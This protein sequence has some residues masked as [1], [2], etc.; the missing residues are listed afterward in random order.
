MDKANIIDEIEKL[1]NRLKNEVFNAYEKKGVA[2]GDKRFDAFKRVFIKT[3]SDII[4]SETNNVNKSLTQYGY[5]ISQFN[6]DGYN[7]WKNKGEKVNAYLE[8]LILDIKND[9]IDL[10]IKKTVP[11]TKTYPTMREKTIKTQ[12]NN[13]VFIVHGHDGEVKSRTA[14]FIEKLGFEAVILHEQASRGKTIIE[15][16]E[17]YTDVGFAIVLYTPDDTGNDI[18]SAGNGQYNLRARQNV[19]FEHGYLIAKI[20]RENVVPLVTDNIEL[21]NDISGVVYVSDSTWEVEIAKEMKQS[22][23]DVDFNKL[24]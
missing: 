7:F 23:Y 19:V 8:S 10:T 3:I 15:K 13:K 5:S 20:G 22:G 9:E 17:T 6:S 4:P 24:Y 2:Y 12:K 11:E 21:P 16:I 14:R 1:Q 18:E